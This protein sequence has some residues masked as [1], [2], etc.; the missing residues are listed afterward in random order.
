MATMDPKK[1]VYEMGARENA[2]GN[3]SRLASRKPHYIVV[4]SDVSQE[5]WV[6]DTYHSKE[7]RHYAHNNQHKES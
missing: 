1:R 6:Q 3:W 7:D 5:V 4:V 2:F